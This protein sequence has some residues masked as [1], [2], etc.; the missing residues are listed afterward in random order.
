MVSSRDGWSNHETLSVTSVSPR[1]SKEALD[2]RFVLAGLTLY[3][4]FD[5]VTACLKIWYWAAEIFLL[6]PS[7]SSSS[8]MALL[9]SGSIDT[10]KLTG[11]SSRVEDSTDEDLDSGERDLDSLDSLWFLNCLM[12]ILACLTGVLACLSGA[13]A[14][15]RKELTVLCG[16]WR[17]LS[18]DLGILSG[19]L[20]GV[21]DLLL[22][23]SCLGAGAAD[24]AGGQAGATGTLDCSI[25]RWS[26]V[27]IDIKSTSVSWFMDLGMEGKSG[28]LVPVDMETSGPP[29]GVI[30]GGVQCPA[31]PSTPS[32]GWGAG[33]SGSSGSSNCSSQLWDALNYRDIRWVVTG[34]VVTCGRAV[35]CG[36][37]VTCNQAVTCCR[38]VTCG[39]VVACGRAVA[40]CQAVT[41]GRAVA[42]CRVGTC[43][44]VRH[45]CR[46]LNFWGRFN[47]N[48]PGWRRDHR[49]RS[50]LRRLGTLGRQLDI[51]SGDVRLT[52]P[53]DTLL[54]SLVVTGRRP[55]VGRSPRWSWWK[56]S[57]IALG[58][59]MM[60]R[61]R[62]RR[63][64]VRCPGDTAGLGMPPE[65]GTA[66]GTW[67]G[68]LVSLRLL[69]RHDD[70]CLGESCRLLSPC[71][72]LRS[73]LLDLLRSDPWV[74]GHPTAETLEA[75]D[76]DWEDSAVVALV[77]VRFVLEDPSDLGR[78]EGSCKASS[79]A[80]ISTE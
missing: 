41:C 55:A 75:T 66:R 73:G 77:F 53:I 69:S 46:D 14:H 16:V 51:P 29:P 67:L 49:D 25:R 3:D 74:L 5:V 20:A 62:G 8:E 37:A 31:D 26:N 71:L 13:L 40:W 7:S 52:R 56:G 61:E 70:W 11:E 50:L 54:S 60:M 30:A 15:L 28:L 72:R 23:E 63:T 9:A 33:P 39:W 32:A 12:G 79:G 68:P 48:L 47:M 65:A 18:G 34:R 6:S 59:M 43:R 17:N 22:V 1:S 21:A 36:Q 64:G 35:T 78:L 24:W 19:V 45:W 4:P 80:C 42:C 2:A 10:V 27:H 76:F 58:M 44:A 38:A 57:T